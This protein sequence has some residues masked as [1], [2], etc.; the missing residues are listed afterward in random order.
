LSYKF[1]PDLCSEAI[2]PEKGILSQILQKDAAVNITLFGMASGEEI[3]SHAAPTP[4]VLYFLEGQARVGLGSETVSAI[5]G[6]F[7]F[8]PPM[9]P[10]SISADS[11]VKMLL[12]QIKSAT[13]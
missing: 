4:A 13:N 8:M 10:H 7:V 9:L 2:I 11:A 5:S 3:S 1:I 6:S 12:I